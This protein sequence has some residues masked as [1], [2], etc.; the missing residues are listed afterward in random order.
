[1][2]TRT[3]AQRFRDKFLD[4]DTKVLREAGVI[5]EAGIHTS[6]GRNLMWSYLFSEYKT[7]L[8]QF[9]RDEKAKEDA[10]KNKK[11]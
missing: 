4:P 10:K 2:A 5:D 1:M 6:D 3:L 11:S 8:A 9:V 7:E